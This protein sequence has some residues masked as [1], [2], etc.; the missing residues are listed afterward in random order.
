MPLQITQHSKNFSAAP[1]ISVNDV[2]EIAQ[3]GF[4]TIFNNRPNAEG[5]ALQPTSAQIEAAAKKHGLDYVYIPVIPNKV[6]DQL[7]AFSAAY[8]QAA[9]PVL[10]FCGT[11]Y[12]AGVIFNMARDQASKKQPE[13]SSKG[14]MGWIKDKL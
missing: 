4:K 12:R 2:A 1:Q 9:K 11:G 3:L 7:P 8:A 14:L 13:A 10:G 6:S 5:G